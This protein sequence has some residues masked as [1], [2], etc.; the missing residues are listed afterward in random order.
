MILDKNLQ[1]SKG[2]AGDV[3]GI[4]PYKTSQLLPIP[5]LLKLQQPRCWYV[6]QIWMNLPWQIWG[7]QEL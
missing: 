4:E 5:N 6:M 3:Y 2:A 1:L 7:Y